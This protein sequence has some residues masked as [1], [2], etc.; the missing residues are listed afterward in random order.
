MLA[1][2]ALLGAP[3]IYEISSLRVNIKKFSH[4]NV[5]VDIEN[6]C[7]SQK[8]CSVVEW[9]VL[10]SCMCKR[11]NTSI[12]FCRTAFFNLSGTADPFKIAI[13]FANPFPTY[14]DMW[15]P[16]AQMTV[17]FKAGML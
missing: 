15:T 6:S 13:N 9:I 7:S 8:T 1:F 5:K 12:A 14:P 11:K 16:K 10:H 3:Y 17:T 4:V 2:L